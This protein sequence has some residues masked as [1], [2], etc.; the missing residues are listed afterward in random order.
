MQPFDIRNATIL[1]NLEI[2]RL[3]AKKSPE[4]YQGFNAY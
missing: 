1:T 2:Q 3:P 4:I